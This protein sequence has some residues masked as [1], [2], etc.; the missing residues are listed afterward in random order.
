M[1]TESNKYCIKYVYNALYSILYSTV[2]FKTYD[3]LLQLH[4]YLNISNNNR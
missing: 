1:I 2:Y 3:L 4:T